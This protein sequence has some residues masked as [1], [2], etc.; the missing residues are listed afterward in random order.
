MDYLQSKTLLSL[1]IL[2][3]FLRNVTKW[4]I[5]VY[6]MTSVVYSVDVPASI[7]E[8]GPNYKIEHS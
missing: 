7:L 1:K 2:N 5:C 3:L 4:T 6:M 8:P